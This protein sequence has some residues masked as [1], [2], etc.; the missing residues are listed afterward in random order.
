MGGHPAARALDVTTRSAVS[1]SRSARAKPLAAKP[2]PHPRCPADTDIRQKL[3]GGRLRSASMVGSPR[4]GLTRVG[5]VL[6]LLAL[7]AVAL[8]DFLLTGFWDRNAMVTSVVADVLVLIVGVAV[9][10]ELLSAR[11]R[12]EWR[13]LS[14]YGLVELGETSRR[15]WVTLSEHVGV[16]KRE[17]LTL[18]EMRSLVRSSQGE[19]RTRK[20]A[21]TV[22]GDG[23]QRKSLHGVVAE[24]A[25]EARG[26]LRRWR[27][28]RDSGRERHPARVQARRGASI[29]R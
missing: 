9:V 17:S 4:T 13:L 26:R 11:S 14:D 7:G 3:T 23:T 12:R 24:L 5:A 15:I 19:E 22:A 21:L 25:E 2:P 10:N 28:D 29:D 20:L 8:S 18:D 1:V 27:L 16:G 6:S